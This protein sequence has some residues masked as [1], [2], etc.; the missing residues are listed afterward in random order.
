MVFHYRITVTDVPHI[1]LR[2]WYMVA[3]PGVRMF[4]NSKYGIAKFQN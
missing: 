1:F 3:F 2:C 4:Y